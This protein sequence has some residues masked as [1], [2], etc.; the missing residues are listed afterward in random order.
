M[1]CSK[2][3]RRRT[4]LELQDVGG[5][6]FVY[7][8]RQLSSSVPSVQPFSMRVR[9]NNP[10]YY[11]R[12]VETVCPVAEL[13]SASGCYSCA[14][15]ASVRVTLDSTCHAGLVTF[16]VNDSPNILLT[17]ASMIITTDPAQYTIFLLT[18]METNDFTL[19][20]FTDNVMYNTSV[21]VTFSAY[22]YAYVQNLTSTNAQTNTTAP[23]DSG[24]ILP[25]P[26]VFGLSYQA[27]VGILAAVG[28]VIAIIIL[29]IIIRCCLCPRVPKTKVL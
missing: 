26:L 23:A 3:K 8:N 15:G 20:V 7:A 22:E 27:E 1:T 12:L 14:I 18:P 29:F 10:V 28:A 16:A 6:P 11:T 17:T 21:H 5:Q 2:S 19:Q 24:V 4:R 25:L 13:V 9:S